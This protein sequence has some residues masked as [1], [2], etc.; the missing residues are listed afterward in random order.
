MAGAGWGGNADTDGSTGGGTFGWGTA[1]AAGAVGGAEPGAAA[2]VGA[3]AE[4]TTAGWPVAGAAGADCGS[5][6]WL[7]TVWL[8]DGA[9][10]AAPG[11]AGT[12]SA[13]AAPTKENNNID[14]SNNGMAVAR[15]PL[16]IAPSPDG[17]LA[18]SEDPLQRPSLLAP[19]PWQ[20]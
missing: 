5:D 14:A 6:G 16:K 7:G 2:L 15:G 4:G 9:P 11:P 17:V 10:V 20:K 18:P 1:T 12:S 19:V 8:L 13:A 3:G